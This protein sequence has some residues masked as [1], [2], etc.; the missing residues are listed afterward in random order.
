M[1]ADANAVA[2]SF[3]NNRQHCPHRRNKKREGLCRGHDML[4]FLVVMLR[5]SLL[6]LLWLLLILV[7][8]SSC[9]WYCFRDPSHG[10]VWELER[11]GD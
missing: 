6:F 5:W 4:L 11:L 10:D 8:L 2:G 1:T 9:C 7:L 3:R